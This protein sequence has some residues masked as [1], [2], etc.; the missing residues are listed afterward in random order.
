M[1]MNSPPNSSM[2]DTPSEPKLSTFPKPMGKLFVGGRKLHDTVARVRMSDAKSV[3]LCQ[4]SA[5][6]AC[7]LNM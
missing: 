7:E 2:P 5:I 4:A 3:K 1:H 6:M